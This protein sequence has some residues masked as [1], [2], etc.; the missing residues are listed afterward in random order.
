[1]SR[2]MDTY[3]QIL[4]NAIPIPDMWLD[5]TKIT[6]LSN[7]D[8]VA[9][10]ADIS[11]NGNNAAQS[12]ASYRPVYNTNIINGLPAVTFNGATGMDIPVSILQNVPGASIFIV[13]KV[14]SKS[15]AQ[16]GT[17]IRICINGAE[18][19]RLGFYRDNTDNYKLNMGG[20]TLDADA[21]AYGIAA[22]TSFVANSNYLITCM[23]DYSNGSVHGYINGG[24][25]VLTATLASSGNTSNT[26]SYY[27]QIGNFMVPTSD[28]SANA[29]ISEIMLYKRI[30]SAA[31]RSIIETFLMN[32]YGIS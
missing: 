31:E 8:T 14:L 18:S 16:V 5:A 23:E 17:F 32:K 20:R 21:Y 13:S 12:N 24:S 1:M 3:R 25:S 10:W 6:G 4:I 9:A 11:G 7:N 19:T 26:A 30:V 28:A 2:R 22:S 15:A 27:A 29:Q